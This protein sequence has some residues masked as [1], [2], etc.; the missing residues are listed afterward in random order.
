LGLDDVFKT[1]SA[2]DQLRYLGKFKVDRKKSLEIVKT[3]FAKR[4]VHSSSAAA[5]ALDLTP[6]KGVI[7]S[8]D[9]TTEATIL[10]SLAEHIES[11]VFTAYASTAPSVPETDVDEHDQDIV[12]LAPISTY[13]RE[14]LCVEPS[15]LACSEGFVA[16]AE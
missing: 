11:P 7:D 8:A 3:L 16:N 14:A 5:S 2:R 9:D 12:L 13:L 10:T 4:L 1:A 15:N 6:G